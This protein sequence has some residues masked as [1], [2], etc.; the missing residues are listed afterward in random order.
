[1]QSKLCLLCCSPVGVEAVKNIVL[2]SINSITL[3]DDRLVTR[4]DLRA[5]FFLEDEDLGLPLAQASL[6][7]LLELNQ[8]VQGECELMD[9]HSAAK[10]QQFL[11]QFSL[12][13]A[14]EFLDFELVALSKACESLEKPL[15]ILKTNGLIGTLR[16]QSPLHYI[17]DS[18]NEKEVYSL[19]LFRPFP[20][21]QKIADSYDFAKLVQYNDKSELAH[22]PFIIIL[23]KALEEWRTG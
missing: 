4:G 13:V 18:K 22:V 5:N 3:V 15:I 9:P 7:H 1:M 2:S 20:Q 21:L 17:I 11:G 19:R 10:N 16:I 12:I 14:S 6:K 8:D 23:I